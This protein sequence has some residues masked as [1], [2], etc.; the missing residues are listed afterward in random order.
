MDFITGLPNSKS[1]IPLFM[2]R[3]EEED[4]FHKISKVPTQLS[5]R[6]DA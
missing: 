2:W 1:C 3:Y 6:L 4:L 5:S